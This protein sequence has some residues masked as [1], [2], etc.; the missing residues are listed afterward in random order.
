[1][2]AGDLAFRQLGDHPD[3]E[4]L[5]VPESVA[6]RSSTTCD[7]TSISAR[8]GYWL[9]E[10]S[11]TTHT[12]PQGSY[13]SLGQWQADLRIHGQA[14]VDYGQRTGTADLEALWMVYDESTPQAQA[15]WAELDETV[16]HLNE[17]GISAWQWVFAHHEHMDALARDHH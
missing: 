4:P 7:T 6:F 5:T 2:K 10:L 8:L 15:V 17:R 13:T 1:M 3:R 14:L 11:T 12:Y 9:L 16:Q